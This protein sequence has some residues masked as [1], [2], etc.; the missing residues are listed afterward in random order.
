MVNLRKS[1]MVLIY[2]C[3]T[4]S[5]EE[6]GITEKFVLRVPAKKSY[7]GYSTV[8]FGDSVLPQKELA[9]HLSE[10]VQC[11]RLAHFTARENIFS[12]PTG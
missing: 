3:L 4:A 8:L 2:S 11:S 7:T 12:F 10:L 5:R 9:A 6:V 1:R